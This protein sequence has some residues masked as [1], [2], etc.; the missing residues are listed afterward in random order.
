[1]RERSK[2]LGR[3]S[4]VTLGRGRCARGASLSDASPCDMT[5]GDRSGRGLALLTSRRWERWAGVM[6]VRGYDAEETQA[7]HEE[8]VLGLLRRGVT[9]E[10]MRRKDLDDPRLTEEERGM[11]LAE[12]APQFAPPDPKDHYLIG[13]DMGDGHADG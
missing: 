12:A 13:M 3:E 2:H 10:E 9:M 11:L 7:R 8:A 1:M 6:R 4:S 5:S